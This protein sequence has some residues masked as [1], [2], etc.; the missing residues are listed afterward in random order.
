MAS[1]K[2][3]F[4]DL[5]QDPFTRALAESNARLEQT[6]EPATEAPKAPSPPRTAPAKSKQPP[7][8]VRSSA[9][10]RSTPEIVELGARQ[11]DELAKTQEAPVQT[12]TRGAKAETKK[13][14]RQRLP[15]KRIEYDREDYNQ[16]EDFLRA[17]SRRSG[18]RLSFNILGRSLVNI[19]MRAE[20]EVFAAIDRHG[21]GERPSNSDAGALAAYEDEWTELLD[22]ALRQSPRAR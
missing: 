1:K 7:K 13:A 21:V 2:K 17:L 10:S 15:A 8:P 18:S 3:A 11:R 4:E 14:P 9:T 12:S 5:S 20:A 16:V 19:A 22:I 6:S